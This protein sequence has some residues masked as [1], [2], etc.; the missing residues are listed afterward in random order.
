MVKFRIYESFCLLISF[1]KSA[2][3]P[4]D[5]SIE[6]VA[7]SN[8]FFDNL[9]DRSGWKYLY[10]K[11]FLNWFFNKISFFN[12]FNPIKLSPRLPVTYISSLT[13]ALFLWI[14]FLE[15]P[16]TVIE[17]DNFGENT[18]SPPH[19]KILNFDCSSFRDLD[20]FLRFDDVNDL[21]L[22]E[23]EIK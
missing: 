12:I 2:I 1:S 17:K 18:V 23:A 19:N 10:I 7:K 9:I 21:S 16:I 5:I 20:N 6:E 13:F 15:K 3:N 14:I 11:Y 8:N 22:P 4:S